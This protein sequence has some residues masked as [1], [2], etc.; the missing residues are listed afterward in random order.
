KPNPGRPALHRLNRAEYANAIRDILALDV[1]ATALLPPDDSSSGFDN[2]ADVLGVSPAL[3]E[4]YLTASS[5]ISRLAVWDVTIRP[6]TVTY[7]TRGDAS[8]TGH[9]EGL[10]LGTRGGLSVHHTFPVDGEY[11]IKVKL[12]E[13]TLGTIRGL[14][15]RHQLEVL[16]D[17][18]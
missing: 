6:A 4:H 10:P 8:Q 2:N 16:L 3:L 14:E 12:L 18:N 1:D 7:R 5:K 13:T 17:G 15:F 9:T 11:V